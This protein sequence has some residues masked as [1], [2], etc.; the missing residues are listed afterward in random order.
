MRKKVDS[1]VAYTEINIATTP[2]TDSS[3]TKTRFFATKSA[4]S[5]H[6]HNTAFVNT[7]ASKHMWTSS[8]DKI[9]IIPLA[10]CLAYNP[11]NSIGTAFMVITAVTS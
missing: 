1:S 10:V 7:H 6:A 8:N 3:S 5:Q 4:Q 2:N 9:Y 11:H